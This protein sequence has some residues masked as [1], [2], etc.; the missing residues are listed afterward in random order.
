[1]R[2]K[3]ALN[4]N[5][6][7]TGGHFAFA[8]ILGSEAV[9]SCCALP[10]PRRGTMVMAQLIP[11]RG[12]QASQDGVDYDALRAA[13]AEANLTWL[14]PS[15]HARQRATFEGYMLRLADPGGGYD[16]VWLRCVAQ[17]ALP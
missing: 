8:L 13:P 11:V 16:I 9:Q 3:T 1:M 14:S 10:T 5:V 2:S 7:A 6:A 17:N 15:P 4:Q 12:A